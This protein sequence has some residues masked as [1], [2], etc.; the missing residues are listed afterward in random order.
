MGV[1]FLYGGNGGYDL[2]NASPDPRRRRG[3]SLAKANA[4]AAQGRSKEARDI[5]TKCV[6]VTPEMAYQLIKVSLWIGY[7]DVVFWPFTN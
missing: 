3:E 6:D 1:G 2:L 5:Y 4:L 7:R